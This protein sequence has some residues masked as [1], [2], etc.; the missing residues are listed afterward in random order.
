MTR[1][2]GEAV[3]TKKWASTPKC[4]RQSQ[5]LLGSGGFRPADNVARHDAMTPQ[6]VTGGAVGFFPGS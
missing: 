4:G 3:A 6:E 5:R 2:R 1:I